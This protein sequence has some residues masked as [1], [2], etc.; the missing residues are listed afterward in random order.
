MRSSKGSVTIVEPF[1]FDGRLR[2][3]TIVALSNVQEP[4]LTDYRYC[5]VPLRL[6]VAA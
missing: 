1:R 2:Q 4:I 6:P 3:G 5:I